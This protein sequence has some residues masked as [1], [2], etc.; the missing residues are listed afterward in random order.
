MYMDG[1]TRMVLVMVTSTARL[2]SIINQSK[3]R[4]SIESLNIFIDVLNTTGKDSI[5]LTLDE[6]ISARDRLEV[7]YEHEKESWLLKNN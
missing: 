1:L 5:I 7:A 2:K 6:L 4:G 3:I